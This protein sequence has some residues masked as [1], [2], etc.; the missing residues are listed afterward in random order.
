M[1]VGGVGGVV[2]GGVSVVGIGVVVGVVCGVIPA[3]FGFIFVSFWNVLAVSLAS[4]AAKESRPTLTAAVA[5][6]VS[7]GA[8]VAVGVDVVVGVVGV[9]FTG[10]E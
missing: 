9:V 8:G 7:V 6:F 4:L 5:D 2:C 3:L 10:V 1:G